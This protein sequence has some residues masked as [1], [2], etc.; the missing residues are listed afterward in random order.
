MRFKMI[1]IFNL[2]SESVGLLK[3]AENFWDKYV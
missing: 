2:F 1:S 3:M